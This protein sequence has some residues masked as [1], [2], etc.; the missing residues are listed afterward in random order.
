[1]LTHSI[2]STC[3]QTDQEEYEDNGKESA[4]NV[5]HVDNKGNMALVIKPTLT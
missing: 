5:L 2:K 1:M 4:I 3:G